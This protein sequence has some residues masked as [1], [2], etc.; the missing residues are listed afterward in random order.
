MHVMRIAQKNGRLSPAG[1]GAITHHKPSGVILLGLD[2]IA[3]R[4]ALLRPVQADI[5]RIERTRLRHRVIRFRKPGQ[6]PG[7][8]DSVFIHIANQSGRIALVPVH[9]LVGVNDLVRY[10]DNSE[11]HGFAG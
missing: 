10:F 2:N 3:Q 6:Q 4:N 8:T 1:V 11:R 7:I 9:M 5:D